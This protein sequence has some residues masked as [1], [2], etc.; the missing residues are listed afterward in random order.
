MRSQVLY[1]QQYGASFHETWQ[2]NGLKV[3]WNFNDFVP[4]LGT[5][6][7]VTIGS[8][9]SHEAIDLNTGRGQSLYSHLGP[10]LHINAS[11]LKQISRSLP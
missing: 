7:E 10:S 8:S 5:F 11:T 9:V 3:R 2:Y 6:T 1:I 4:T